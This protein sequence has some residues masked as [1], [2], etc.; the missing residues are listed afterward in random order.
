M[1]RPLRV[2]FKD[3]VY[4][5]TSKGNAGN[6]I[7]RDDSDKELFLETVN[8]VI[9]KYKWKYHAYSILENQYCLVIETPKPNLS[10]GMRQLNGIYTQKF[11]RKYDL[12]GHVFQGRFK[13]V[14]IEKEKY[15]L[16]VCRHV[17]LLPSITKATRNY[18]TYKWSSYRATAG[19]TEDTGFLDTGWILSQFAKRTKNAQQKYI[20][21]VK[22]GKKAD[23]PMDDV[24]GQI[25]LG[26]DSFIQKLKPQLIKGRS[27]KELPKWQRNLSRPPIEEVFKNIEGKTLK[28][29]NARIKQA[30]EIFGYTLKQIGEHLGLHYTSVSR[31]INSQ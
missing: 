16:D 31:I 11:N 6:P 3:A 24:R 13:A 14:L 27:K 15:L 12:A 22:E 26:S 1:A 10:V 17:V 8:I 20:Q 29:R 9:D 7:T 25:L 23:S 4:Y 18:A 5:V 2:E 28:Q 21:Y 19:L 30:N